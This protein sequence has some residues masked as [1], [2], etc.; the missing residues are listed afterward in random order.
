MAS[1]RESRSAA[2]GIHTLEEFENCESLPSRS[3]IVLF[4]H[5]RHL[6]SSTKDVQSIKRSASEVSLGMLCEFACILIVLHRKNNELLAQIT[7]LNKQLQ[8]SAQENFQLRG[9]ISTL[10]RNSLT[11]QARAVAFER[12]RQTMVDL[13]DEV[14]RAVC[15]SVSESPASHS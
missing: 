5:S 14:N 12:E 8:E 13:L 7:I 10:K 15:S 6:L 11:H 1:R 3:L 2:T 4:V 9:E